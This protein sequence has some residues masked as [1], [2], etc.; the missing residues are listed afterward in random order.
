MSEKTSKFTIDLVV[1]DDKA[2]DSIRDI[3]KD[4]KRVQAS[5]TSGDAT[6]AVE[7]ML[8]D[9][10]MSAKNMQMDAQKVIDYYAK[11]SKN[12]ISSLEAEYVKL[13]EVQ[14]N[15]R[16]TK[17]ELTAQKEKLLAQK[18]RVKTAEEE[19]ELAFKLKEIEDKIGKLDNVSAQIEKNRQL[20]YQIKAATQLAQ[21][22][23]YI[24]KIEAVQNRAQSKG[25][26]EKIKYFL[27]QRKYDNEEIKALKEKIKLIETE[28]RQEKK[29]G[30]AVKAVAKEQEKTLKSGRLQNAYNVAGLIGGVGR[31]IGGAVRTAS[32]IAKAGV[33]ILGQG[34]AAASNAAN[35][36]V[37]K[38]RLANRVKGYSHKDAR[39]IL[40][41]LYV[42]TGADYPA[43]VDAI[44]RVQGTLGNIKNMSKYDLLGAAE[45]E[46]R[47]P[48]M[49]LAFASESG[50]NSGGVEGYKQYAAKLKA[51]QKASGASDDQIAS[52][53][54]KFAN[55][56]AINLSGGAV[57]DYQAVYL[58]MQ[59]SGAF[60]SDEELDKAFDSFLRKQRTSGKSVFRFAREFDWS[61]SA[62]GIR[63]KSQV[64]N[65][66]RGFNW[67]ALTDEISNANSSDV[68]N[69][70]DAE[71]TAM[72]MRRM[73]EQKNKL[74]MTL[75]PA[76]IPLVEALAK[77]L[78]GDGVRK[79][80]KGMGDLFKVVM[81][82]L[83]KV[84]ETLDRVILSPLG[85]VIDGLSSWLKDKGVL[86]EKANGGIAIGPSIVG[87]RAF[88]PEMI[89]PLDYSRSSRAGNIIQNVSQTFNMGGSETTA[90]SLSQAVKSRD[91][92]RATAQNAFISARGGLL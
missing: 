11:H 84:L 32:G 54:Q 55:T 44:N 13:R 6:K 92:R 4:I 20:R 18:A 45:I 60:E 63:N 62:E 53:V 82:I 79:L 35:Q 38:E 46:L 69:K 50:T 23:L 14:D 10:S 58:A 31:T 9:L 26:K 61:A 7:K 57:S 24:S 73:E 74:L 75:I 71:N 86:D 56:K 78:E 64:Q 43:I 51:I 28:E 52:S 70:T 2:K 80:A 59:N 12:A 16:E 76:A 22:E 40:N 33:G 83:L 25:I 91:F 87:E 27:T 1:S 15:A 21:K 88:Q 19:V 90:L 5:K 48:G 36:E 77:V 3:E 68:L 49:S 65:T 34:L 47:Y 37:E 29:L 39:N 72:N 30:Q 85:E 41:E 81:P 8:K 89:L 42:R 17:S 67:D 66:M